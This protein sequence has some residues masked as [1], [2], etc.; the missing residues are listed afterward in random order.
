MIQLR[1]LHARA[2]L[3][4][5]AQDLALLLGERYPHAKSMTDEVARRCATELRLLR[6]A[7]ARAEPRAQQYA[8]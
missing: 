7:I 4:A 6:Q 1:A 5:F 3:F 8:N 2:S